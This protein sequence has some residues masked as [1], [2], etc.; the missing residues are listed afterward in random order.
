[1]NLAQGLGSLEQVMRIIEQLSM[2]LNADLFPGPVKASKGSRG[3]GIEMCPHIMHFW[4][5]VGMVVN[6]STVDSP[7]TLF[8]HAF[9]YHFWAHLCQH[10]LRCYITILE[11]RLSQ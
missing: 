11:K 7:W 6:M 10:F 4:G 5:I 2:W 3:G 8:P 9:L 1:M